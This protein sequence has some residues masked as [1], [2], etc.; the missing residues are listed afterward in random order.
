LI[1]SLDGSRKTRQIHLKSH[2]LRK[3]GPSATKTENNKRLESESKIKTAAEAEGRPNLRDLMW[4]LGEVDRANMPLRK[5]PGANKT[6]TTSQAPTEEVGM[7]TTSRTSKSS[8]RMVI[9]TLKTW[10]E[11]IKTCQSKRETPDLPEQNSFRGRQVTVGTGQ[12]RTIDNLRDSR[13]ISSNMSK[14]LGTRVKIDR[15]V[16]MITVR[17]REED[18]MENSRIVDEYMII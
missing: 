18:D 8:C 5:S 14:A 15:E 17:D 10:R 12:A 7:S 3:I 2:R 6:T 13:E 11:P 16:G 9:V 1:R 4:R